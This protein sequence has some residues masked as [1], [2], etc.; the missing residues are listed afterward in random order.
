MITS[1]MSCM[2]DAFSLRS[3]ASLQPLFM[4]L[5]ILPNKG[6]HAADTKTA[7]QWV[8]GHGWE[9]AHWAGGLPNA[10]WI[11]AIS[12]HNPVLLYRMDIHMVLLNTVAL[13]LAGIDGSTL[14][15]EGGR[16]MHGSDGK[17]TGILVYVSAAMVRAMLYHAAF[18]AFHHGRLGSSRS[19]G[20][21]QLH[22]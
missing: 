3:D 13:E 5:V 2:Q 7:N 6:T 9:E 14:A 17:P 12:P 8:M 11:D 19:R 16:I 18:A 15:P 22:M 4:R 1:H 10:D 21:V 20:A